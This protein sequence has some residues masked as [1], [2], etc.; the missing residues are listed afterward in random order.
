MIRIDQYASSSTKIIY[1][2]KATKSDNVEPSKCSRLTS[3]YTLIIFINHIGDIFFF[4]MLLLMLG[5]TLWLIILALRCCNS[6]RSLCKC[7]KSHYI[8]IKLIFE[9]GKFVMHVEQGICILLKID[10][11]FLKSLEYKILLLRIWKFLPNAYRQ[12]AEYDF[13]QFTNYQP[14]MLGIKSMFHRGN[15]HY[16]C[17]DYFCSNNVK[18]A[19]TKNN[20]V[21]PHGAMC[22]LFI[23]ISYNIFDK[24]IGTWVLY[25]IKHKLQGQ[26]CM[27]LNLNLAS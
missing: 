16:A 13:Q 10:L 17:I 21:K 23:I 7:S 27:F 3:I 24:K 22:T 8:N 6:S 4:R 2:L 1:L 25:P 26:Y 14:V 18:T 15:L 19:C 11:S 5:F 20:P 9:L 12:S